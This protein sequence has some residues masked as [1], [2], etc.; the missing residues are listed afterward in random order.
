MKSILG[1]GILLIGA[2]GV[3]TAAEEHYGI[4]SGHTYPSLEF[5]HMGMSI[6]RGKFAKTTG[7]IMMDRAAHTGT[8]NV[9]VDMNSIDFGMKAM[10]DRAKTEDYF[11][12]AKYP[13][14]TYT[15]KLVFAGDNV[16]GVDG[17]LTMKGIAKPLHLDMALFN[18]IQH[19]FLHRPVCGGEATGV[20][21]WKDFGI[22]M[23]PEGNK[24]GDAV[25]LHIQVES[26]KQDQ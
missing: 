3:A 12:T 20:V 5:G 23:D 21:H 25:T 17:T 15:G 22:K 26:V 19:P 16:S 8:V 1:P 9:K 4:E 7:D 2:L 10:D 18:C 11:D 6:W 14:M 13:T 24:M